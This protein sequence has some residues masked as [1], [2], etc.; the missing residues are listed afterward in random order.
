MQGHHSVCSPAGHAVFASFDANSDGLLDR[1]ELP[2]MYDPAGPDH[3]SAEPDQHQGG[4]AGKAGA[5]G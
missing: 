2:S 3:W 4:K 1:D 5:E